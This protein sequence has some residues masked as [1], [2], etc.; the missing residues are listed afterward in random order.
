MK[1]SK[2]GSVERNSDLASALATAQTLNG[3]WRE[4]FREQERVQSLGVRDVMDAMNQAFVKSNR[5]VG[6]IVNRDAQ[7][8]NAGGK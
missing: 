5:T 8:A 3:D 7:T 2:I 6:M 4:F 1:A